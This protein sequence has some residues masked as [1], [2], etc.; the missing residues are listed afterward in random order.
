[1]AT[2]K[3]VAIRA[4]ELN[5]V[6]VSTEGLDLMQLGQT[7]AASGYFRDTRDAAQAVVKILYGQEVGI[8]PVTAMMGV[9][10]IEG[11]PAPS[12]NL[13]AARIKSSGRYNYRVREHSTTVCQIEFFERAP[14]GWESLGVV[15]WSMEDAKRAGLGGRGPWRTYPRA[16]LFAR[17]ISEGAR[18][19]C[20][21]IFGGAPVYTPEELGADVD[22]DGHVVTVGQRQEAEPLATEKQLATIREMAKSSVITD[23]ERAHIEARIERGLT[24]EE[25]EGA[26]AWL[27]AEIPKRKAAAKEA[28]E[29]IRGAGAEEDATAEEGASEGALNTIAELMHHGLITDDERASIQKGLDSAP[30]AAWAVK[31]ID[32]LE[33]VIADRGD[34]QEAA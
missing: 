8:G 10:I 24:V 14:Q 34:A 16:M 33:R 21:E 1:M 4:P 11:K 18:T 7:M 12:A 27:G 29:T 31:V 17:A 26:Y 30:T 19:H 25:W 6:T 32:R 22:A 15:E 20:P 9:H 13:I 5:G 3:A 23:K 28:A 2:G